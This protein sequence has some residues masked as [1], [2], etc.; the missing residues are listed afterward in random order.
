MLGQKQLLL[1]TLTSSSIPRTIKHPC[2]SEFDASL[3]LVEG[4]LSVCS[5]RIQQNRAEVVCDA[6]VA[7]VNR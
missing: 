1:S 7:S 6:R 3:G 4:L 5:S 2:T